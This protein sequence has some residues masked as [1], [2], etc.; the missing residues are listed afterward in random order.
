MEKQALSFAGKGALIGG[1][2]GGVGGGLRGYYAPFD[3][4]TG[5]RLKRPH[6]NERHGHAIARGVLGA[7]GGAYA[8]ATLGSLKDLSKA[9]RHAPRPGAGYDPASAY[10][11]RQ[12]AQAAAGDFKTPLPF[13]GVKNMEEGKKRYR[14]LAFAAHP[15]RGGNEAK[16]KDLNQA[17]A[18]MKNHPKFQKSAM[19]SGFTSE[20]IAILGL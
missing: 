12:K 19:L 15:D 11:A 7:V 9:Y 16:M 2:L 1:A 18:K 5:E 17:W 8:G 3:L 14:D 4:E 10:N 13:K 6:K 20:M